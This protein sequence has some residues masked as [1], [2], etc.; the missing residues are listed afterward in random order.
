MHPLVRTPTL[1]VSTEPREG[2]PAEGGLCEAHRASVFNRL[3]LKERVTEPRSHGATDS[4]WLGHLS[5]GSV[6]AGAPPLCPRTMTCP[7]NHLSVIPVSAPGHPDGPHRRAHSA[8]AQSPVG[9][10][11][12][13]PPRPPWLPRDCPAPPIVA[14]P[15][16]GWGCGTYGIWSTDEM[17]ATRNLSVTVRRFRREMSNRLWTSGWLKACSGVTLYGRWLRA[18]RRGP[19][20]QTSLNSRTTHARSSG[21]P[22]RPQEAGWRVWRDRGCLHPLWRLG[23]WRRL[24]RRWPSPSC[25]PCATRRG[26][27]HG[28][29][30]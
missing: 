5:P 11:A 15:R 18:E 30:S 28:P 25:C 12:P 21:Q 1:L 22:S 26:Q 27:Q 6:G 10:V 17:M 19:A 8:P 7:H 24:A 14:G 13:R 20:T 3:H 16:P 2:R 9:S 23:R 4:C 29:L